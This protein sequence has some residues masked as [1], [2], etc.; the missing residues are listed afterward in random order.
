MDLNIYSIIQYVI[1]IG[2]LAH[3]LTIQRSSTSTLAWLLIILIQPYIGLPFYLMFG[4]R[5]IIRKEPL[6][7][8][9]PPDLATVKDPVQKILLASGSPMAC[10]NEKIRFLENGEMAYET[11]IKIIKEAKNYIYLE[12]FIFSNDQVGHWVLESLTAKAKEGIE[13]KILLDSLGAIMPGHPSFKDYKAAG[14]KISMFMPLIHKP[15]QGSANLRNHRKLVVVDD[16]ISMIGGMNI[17]EEY[18]GPTALASRWVDLAMTMEG[19]VVYH[20]KDLFL[21]DW[22]FATKTEGV[23]KNNDNVKPKEEKHHAQLVMSGPD[24][25]T[26]PI[27][28]LL[29]TAIYSAKKRIW[30]TTPYFVPDESLAKAIELAARRGVDVRLVIPAKS[31]HR[32]AD[33]ARQSYLEQI[34]NSG[35]TIYQ[36]PK[37]IHAKLTLVDDSYG[38]IGSANMDSRSLLL[39]YE[40][41]VCLYSIGEIKQLE[42]WCDG[43]F[44]VSSTEVEKLTHAHQWFGRLARLFSPLI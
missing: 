13:V 44:A 21:F 31:N 17:A 14:G 29:L 15:F 3:I 42:S 16:K 28:E 30:I 9:F 18:M 40:L 8:P 36:Y 27:Y 39:N 20:I 41:G 4:S 43:I 38:F 26:D 37:M 5:K 23:I 32:M 22:A 7:F 19:P 33:F 1:V 10:Y 11:L 34:Q 12:T 25:K 2:F 6:L 24:I 35:A